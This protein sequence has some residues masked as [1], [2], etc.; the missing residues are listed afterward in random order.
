M[1]VPPW[2]QSGHKLTGKRRHRLGWRKTLVLQVEVT[3]YMYQFIDR[4]PCSNTKWYSVWRDATINDI[5]A[6]ELV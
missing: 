3:Y 2:R 1:V 6:G 4:G 5:S